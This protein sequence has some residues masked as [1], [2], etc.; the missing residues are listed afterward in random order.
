MTLEEL[1]SRTRTADDAKYWYADDAVTT[2]RSV[3]VLN[4]LRRYRS[5]EANMRRRTRESMGMGETD[6][7]ALRFLLDAQRR[8]D[9]V[10]PKD[11]T[12]YLGISSASTTILID[13]LA[14]TGHVE[15]QPHPSDRRGLVIV[16]TAQTE[17]EVR[18]TL[19]RMHAGMIA[20]AESLDP[21]TAAAIVEFLD[22]INDVIDEVER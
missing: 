8:G 19:G 5:S 3:D 13:R 9:Q 11:L 21:G 12:A 20:I 14:K 22:D 7:L 10:S 6:L 2:E 16:P 4:A 15:R 18:N 17:R 1:D